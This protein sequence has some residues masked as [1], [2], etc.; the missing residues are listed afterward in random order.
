MAY[1]KNN[2]QIEGNRTNSDRIAELLLLPCLKHQC[3]E[4]EGLEVQEEM[5]F[6]KKSQ[7]W[8]AKIEI[9]NEWDWDWRIDT[10]TGANVSII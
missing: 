9:K 10:D 3:I 2:I 5:C 8:K 4:Q 7:W 6:C 1:V